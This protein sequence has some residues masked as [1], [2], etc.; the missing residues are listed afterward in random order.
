ME[1]RRN[2]KPMSHFLPD[3][4][5]FWTTSEINS[6]LTHL[7]GFHGDIC[8]IEVVGHSSQGQLMR[9]LTISRNRGQIDGSRPIVFLDAGIHA[10]EWATQTGTMYMINEMVTKRTE[11]ADILNGID[12]VIIPNANPDGYDYSRT[13]V[14]MCRILLFSIGLIHLLG[15]LMAKNTNT[16][17]QH[18]WNNLLRS[19]W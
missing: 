15:S 8:S 1:Y 4:N 10:R 18:Y 9:A 2:A 14:I 13:D 7:I 11:Y 5:H 16:I 12:L 3:F 6:Y 17:G 19:Q